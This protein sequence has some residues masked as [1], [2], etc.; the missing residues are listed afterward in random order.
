M[1]VLK[2]EPTPTEDV[3]PWAVTTRHNGRGF[4]GVSVA[5]DDLLVLVSEGADPR[6]GTMA[7][8]T[9]CGAATVQCVQ[10]PQALM[11]TGGHPH[12]VPQMPGLAD[13]VAIVEGDVLVLCSA[14]ALEYLPRGFGLITDRLRHSA[15]ALD[16]NR[17]LAEILSYAKNGAAAIV[18]RRAVNAGPLPAF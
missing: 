13:Q 9:R 6:S 2:A 1:T 16:P 18:S 15:E 4:A 5:G 14:G 7:R 11:V 17:L 12:L 3:H 10:A 8:L